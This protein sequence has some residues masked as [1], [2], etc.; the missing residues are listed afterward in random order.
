MTSQASNGKVS[1]GG[2][3]SG[4]STKVKSTVVHWHAGPV[5]SL[6]F[7]PADSLLISG[8]DEGVVFIQHLTSG[9]RTFCPRL[10]GVI[11]RLQFSSDC[12]RIYAL[13]QSNEIL[14]IHFAD[15]QIKSLVQGFGICSA[16]DG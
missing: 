11:N 6:L 3:G 8:G 15:Y 4:G 14:E 16:G 7:N 2:T 10:G 5:I 13:M 1:D 9:K 12:E